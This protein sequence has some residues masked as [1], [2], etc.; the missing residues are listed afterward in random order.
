[1]P[2]RPSPGAYA[3]LSRSGPSGIPGPRLRSSSCSSSCSCK[4]DWVDV[5]VA[6]KS[7]EKRS[8]PNGVI[9]RPDLTVPSPVLGSAGPWRAAIRDA[10]APVPRGGPCQISRPCQHP[11]RHRLSGIGPRDDTGCRGLFNILLGLGRAVGIDRRS[12]PGADSAAG[13]HLRSPGQGVMDS[14]TVRWVQPGAAIVADAHRRVDVHL[15]PR[16]WSAVRVHLHP[17]A[18]GYPGPGLHRSPPL[19]VSVRRPDRSPIPGPAGGPN[20]LSLQMKRTARAQRSSPVT[21]RRGT[22]SGRAEAG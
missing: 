5:H 10:A 18:R 7:V 16:W 9:P 20:A 4:G 12:L 17:G 8:S 1:M 14:P 22:G 21:D 19:E 15:R 11:R 3:V 2:G 6:G 13:A